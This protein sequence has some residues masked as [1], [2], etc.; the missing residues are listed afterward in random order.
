MKHLE[1][2]KRIEDIKDSIDC[3]ETESIESYL[4]GLSFSESFIMASY[5]NPD[6]DDLLIE[7]LSMV[8]NAGKSDV[9]AVLAEMI[10]I[11]S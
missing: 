4:Y 6:L 11:L 9:K 1:L 5:E 8:R 2:Q 7:S 10:A 3:V